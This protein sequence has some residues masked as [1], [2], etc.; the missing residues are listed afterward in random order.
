MFTQGKTVGSGLGE[1][2]YH[3]DGRPDLGEIVLFLCRSLPAGDGE[4]PW[5]HGKA[6]WD[7]D[8]SSHPEEPVWGT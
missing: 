7:R 6:G 1:T 3:S 8:T 4:H 2:K 5:P